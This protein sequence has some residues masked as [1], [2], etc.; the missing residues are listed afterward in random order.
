MDMVLILHNRLST[1][2]RKIIFDHSS[3]YYIILIYYNL[4]M[5]VSFKA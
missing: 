5:L 2:V 4:L 3:Y 1:I